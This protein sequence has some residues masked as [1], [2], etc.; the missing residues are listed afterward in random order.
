MKLYNFEASDIV[1]LKR[2]Y[3]FSEN[4]NPDFE[5]N[6]KEIRKYT[7]LEKQA[8]HAMQSLERPYPAKSRA[9][10]CPMMSALINNGHLI[11]GESPAKNLYE[12]KVAAQD[13]L[14]AYLNHENID[15]PIPHDRKSAVVVLPKL[16]K[17]LKTCDK[18]EFQ[19]LSKQ[20]RELFYSHGLNFSIIPADS[21]GLY[22]NAVPLMFTAPLRDPVVRK[23]VS[24]TQKYDN[25]IV[26]DLLRSFAG[27][28][29]NNNLNHED[30]RKLVRTM[31][32]H[33][34]SITVE[35]I[36]YLQ[37][38][39]PKSDV[40]KDLYVKFETDKSIDEI[41]LPLYYKRDENHEYPLVDINTEEFRKVFK[42]LF[43]TKLKDFALKP[44]N[45]E[46]DITSI[47]I[48]TEKFI[49]AKLAKAL[50]EQQAKL[51]QILTAT[52]SKPMDK[53]YLNQALKSL[54]VS[55]DYDKVPKTKLEAELMHRTLYKVLNYML[56]NTLQEKCK[57][58]LINKFLS[59]ERKALAINQ[60]FNIMQ[61]DDFGY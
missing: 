28:I 11:W 30:S 47:A 29:K 10:I 33:R 58:Q 23:V 40:I 22:K 6:R 16:L 52:K 36:A 19:I 20:L 49:P 44:L 7:R 37:Y 38:V 32:H 51:D 13:F 26:K 42:A 54:K 3:I 56:F 8:L 14:K 35:D 18:Q 15:N 12:L 46:P 2:P 60:L 59:A 25:P 4:F 39:L 17:I 57:K 9:N 5:V 50:K 43:N 45:I 48:L 61:Q 53:S 27:K 21:K 1:E 41:Y 24:L 55:L 34:P 31:Q